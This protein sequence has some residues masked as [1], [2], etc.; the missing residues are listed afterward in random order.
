MKLSTPWL[1]VLLV[2]VLANGVLLG[3]LLHRS[4]DGPSWRAGHG[5]RMEMR[6]SGDRRAGFALHGFVGA[7][8]EEVRAEAIA[9]VRGEMSGM[10]DLMS[11]AHAARLEVERLLVEDE[12]DTDA[13]IAAMD[14]LNARHREIER[15]IEAAV[16]DVLAGL[17]RETRERAMAAGLE[18]RLH[19]RRHG[20]PH[21]RRLEPA[22]AE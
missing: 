16:L 6:H 13:V 10:G 17:D 19:H 8:P 14:D 15:R 7:L 1:I 9:R 2:S 12:F 22:P 3:V 18:R 5:E 21:E 20:R 11:Q 4:A